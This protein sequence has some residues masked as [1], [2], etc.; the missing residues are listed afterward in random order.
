MVQRFGE[1]A[2]DVFGEAGDLPPLE[3]LHGLTF[4]RSMWGPV[5]AQLSLREPA[6]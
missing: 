6:R 4:D 5:V 3:L 1:L 2:A